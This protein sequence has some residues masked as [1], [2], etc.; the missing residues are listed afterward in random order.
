MGM[1]EMSDRAV[2]DLG[3]AQMPCAVPDSD[4][5]PAFAELEAALGA[6]TG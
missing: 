4:A 6:A 2:L 5:E 1:F 3:G